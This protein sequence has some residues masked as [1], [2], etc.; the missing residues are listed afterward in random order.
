MCMSMALQTATLQ[1][2]ENVI[3]H[4][5]QMYNAYKSTI[6]WLSLIYVAISH[7]RFQKNFLPSEADKIRRAEIKSGRKNQVGF[8]YVKV[9]S[10]LVSLYY[11]EPSQDHKSED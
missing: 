8:C 10:L 7:S 11:I 4:I 2:R 3:K 1:I 9:C 6:L 5:R